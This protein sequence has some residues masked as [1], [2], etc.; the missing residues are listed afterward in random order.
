MSKSDANT[1]LGDWIKAKFVRKSNFAEKVGADPTLVSRWL[2]G[3]G[4]SDEYQAKIRKLGYLGPFP[5]PEREITLA[6]LESIRAEVRT[7]AAWVR[8]ELRKENT[9]LAADLEK[10]LKQLAELRD[11]P[12]RGSK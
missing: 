4:I 1:N 11:N 3:K 10:V 9:A 5:E 6:D 2:G 12:L 8:E 7:Q